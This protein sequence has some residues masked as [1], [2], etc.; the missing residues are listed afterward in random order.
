[1]VILAAS[2]LAPIPTS[3][4][5]STAPRWRD[6]GAARLLQMLVLALCTIGFVLPLLSVLV[7]GLGSGMGALL[8]RPSFWWAAASS[9]VIGVSSAL[10][11]LALALALALGR[12]ATGSGL[13]R[14]LL[15]M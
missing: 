2:A 9:L 1:L 4:G 3:F 6:A 12:G 11:T 14:T 8:A 5:A 15:G 7:D 13:L 10:L